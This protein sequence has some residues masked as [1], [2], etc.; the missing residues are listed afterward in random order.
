MIYSDETY[1]N[2]PAKIIAGYRQTDQKGLIYL[3]YINDSGKI[4]K[5]KSWNDWRS[6]IVEPKEFDNTPIEGIKIVGHGGGKPRFSQRQAYCQI[7]DPRGFEVQIS[8]DNLLWLLNFGGYVFDKETNTG[9]FDIKCVYAWNGPTLIL[10]P[11]DSD[12][13]KY[14]QHV[15]NAKQFQPKECVVGHWYKEPNSVDMMY[16]GSL[17]KLK[18]N[19]PIKENKLYYPDGFI[20]DEIKTKVEKKYVFIKFWSSD[21]YTFEE[22][23]AS[24]KRNGGF[25]ECQ[26]L[27]E[28]ES[29]VQKYVNKWYDQYGNVVH[30]SI[31]KVNSISIDIINTLHH[32]INEFVNT[33]LPDKPGIVHNSHWKYGNLEFIEDCL[34][35]SRNTVS[36]KNVVFLDN[37]GSIIYGNLFVTYRYG[38]YD[39]LDFKRLCCYNKTEEESLEIFKKEAKKYVYFVPYTKFFID[40]F[41][42]KLK[43]DTTISKPINYPKETRVELRY[44]EMITHGRFEVSAS[45]FFNIHCEDS[46]GEIIIKRGLG[47]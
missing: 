37:D 3:S 15:N 1:L 36:E 28:P 4:A 14:T 10:C 27:P 38:K 44:D 25:I 12:D 19:D 22:Y 11:V 29:K 41:D 34:H 40:I 6:K 24:L 7:L 23:P 17:Y 5:E 20:T 2:I 18:F 43:I 26:K 8:F 13:Y 46:N 31:R 9:Y 32:K 30:S 45:K 16:L 47:R 39:W 33:T 42:G 21:N 35:L